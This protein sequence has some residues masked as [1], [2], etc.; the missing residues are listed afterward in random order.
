MEENKQALEIDDKV[1]EADGG[2]GRPTDI[3][4]FFCMKCNKIVAYDRGNAVDVTCP[5]CKARCAPV[6][7]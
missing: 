3:V 4:P 2:F 6:I 5:I 1:V 7:M